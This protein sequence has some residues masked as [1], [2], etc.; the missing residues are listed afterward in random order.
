MDWFFNGIGTQIVIYILGIISGVV[1]HKFYQNSNNRQSQKAGNGA[2]QIQSNGLLFTKDR[3]GETTAVQEGQKLSV[4]DYVNGNKIVSS[5]PSEFDICNFSRYSNTQIEGIVIARGNNATLRAWCL[6]LILNH[7][8]DY[9]IRQC[10]EKWITTKKN[11]D[12]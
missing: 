6:E 12:Y 1:G 10:V 7:R 5:E 9:L 11:T 2:I 3:E 8:Q 4:G